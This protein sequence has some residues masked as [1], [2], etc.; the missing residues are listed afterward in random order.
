[1]HLGSF[2][3]LD[4]NTAYDKDGIIHLKVTFRVSLSG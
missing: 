1:M 3:I 2:V 4:N